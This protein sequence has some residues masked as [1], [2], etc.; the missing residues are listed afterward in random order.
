MDS[1]RVGIQIRRERPED[2][3]ETEELV[4]EAFWNV[5]HP[6]CTEHYL[7]HCFRTKEEF[8]PELDLV[9]E[10]D[11][12]IIGQI[13][14]V[15]SMILK[16]DGSELPVMTFGPL[17]IH[18]EYARKGYGKKLLDCSMDA[19]RKL[20]AGALVITGNIE[21]YGKSGFVTGKSVGIRY[22]EDPDA[23]YLLVKELK[24]DY[25][26]D[27]RGTFTDPPGYLE[28][29]RDPEAF[30]RYDRTF[31]KKEKKKLPGQLE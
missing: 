1:N 21:F 25:L 2:Y 3:R 9:M 27:V 22:A 10:K 28:A 23:D 13:M 15:H 30:E 7:L 12:R 18:P 20:G 26:R 31:P 6:G 14:Y 11:G 19:A 16:E 29:V 8:I 24:K 17:S 4:R 5:Y